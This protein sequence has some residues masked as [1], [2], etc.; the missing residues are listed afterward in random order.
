M[1]GPTLEAAWLTTTGPLGLWVIGVA[2]FAT[3]GGG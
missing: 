3:G 1:I 2:L